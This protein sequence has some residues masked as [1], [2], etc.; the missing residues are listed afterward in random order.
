MRKLFGILFLLLCTV[1]LLSA[2]KTL[3][4]YFWMWKVARPH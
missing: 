3:E 1:S 4:M 2:A